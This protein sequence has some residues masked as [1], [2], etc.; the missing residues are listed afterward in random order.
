MYAP[1]YA[2]HPTENPLQ[3]RDDPGQF[4]TSGASAA[5]QVASFVPPQS[6]SPA[7]P[8]GPEGRPVVRHPQQLRLHRALAEFG[9]TG[10]IK[11][12]NQTARQSHLSVTTPILITTSGTILR[13]WA[14]A[15]G[16][17]QRAH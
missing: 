15:V 6:F 12:F 10:E 8:S 3:S 13:L 2:P 1:E 7:A 16:G 5:V 14:L 11:E 17:F 9:W 4:V